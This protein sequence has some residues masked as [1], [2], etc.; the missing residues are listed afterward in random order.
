YMIMHGTSD[1]TVKLLLN[2]INLGTI[3]SFV[4]YATML[5]GQPRSSET[6]KVKN[7]LQLTTL[8][9]GVASLLTGVFAI[10][11][12]R[13]LLN[14]NFTIDMTEYNVKTITFVLM[15]IAAIGFYNG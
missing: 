15:V 6:I 12:S 11:L 14:Y 1:Y 8:I 7:S 3:A 13:F 5:F 2:L 10:P 9:L 4:K